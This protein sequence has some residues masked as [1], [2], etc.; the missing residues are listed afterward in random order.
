MKSATAIAKRIKK[1]MKQKGMSASNLIENCKLSPTII[2]NI[3][4]E[5]TKNVLMHSIFEITKALNI[6]VQ[7]FF[8]DDL[9]SLE[10]LD[11]IKKE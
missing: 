4:Q 8:E 9:L 5:K 2:N 10:N 11:D 3:L 7:E 1:L 6:S